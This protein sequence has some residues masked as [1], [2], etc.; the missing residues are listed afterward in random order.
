MIEYHLIGSGFE[1]LTSRENNGVH[2]SLLWNRTDNSLR[3]AVFDAST[4]SAFELEVGDAPP[5]DVFNHPYAYAAYRHIGYAPTFEP[6]SAA[7]V[8]A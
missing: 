7:T 2:V 3:V 4:E 5:L 6:T 1:E 8:A